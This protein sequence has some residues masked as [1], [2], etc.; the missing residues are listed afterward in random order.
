ML[1]NLFFSPVFCACGSVVTPPRAIKVWGTA[2]GQLSALRYQ[3]IWLAMQAT[4]TFSKARFPSSYSENKVWKGDWVKQ[5]PYELRDKH[6][7]RAIR[8]T[9]KDFGWWSKCCLSFPIACRSPLSQRSLASHLLFL[10]CIM[11]TASLPLST[12]S[13]VLTQHHHAAAIRR[14]FGIYS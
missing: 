6:S 4:T 13:N 14:V 5:N 9:K 12:Q 2:G 7:P 8:R 3:D 10:V 1:F 11:P